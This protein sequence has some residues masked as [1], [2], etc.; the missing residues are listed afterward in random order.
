MKS[1]KSH[2]NY[3][4]FFDNMFDENNHFQKKPVTPEKFAESFEFIE[5][6][7]KCLD[8]L[9]L[10]QKIAFILK[11]VNDEETQDILSELNI[12]TSNLGVLLFRARNQLRLCIE[13]KLEK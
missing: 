4:A 10:N 1:L 9:P 12:S 5:I 3:E 6:A 8:F 2:I 7:K 11:E 13:N